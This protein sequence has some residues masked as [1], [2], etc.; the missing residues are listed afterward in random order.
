MVNCSRGTYRKSCRSRSTYTT[1]FQT[2]RVQLVSKTNSETVSLQKKFFPPSFWVKEIIG[3][4]EKQFQTYHIVHQQLQCKNGSLQVKSRVKNI[5]CLQEHIGQS[6]P[7]FT[8][9]FLVKGRSLML[10]TWR[11]RWCFRPSTCCNLLIH[12]K[13]GCL[14]FQKQMVIKWTK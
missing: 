10:H 2:W 3:F 13:S 7:K 1:F 4:N 12:P 14:L 6:E 8:M 5:Y 11:L 9:C